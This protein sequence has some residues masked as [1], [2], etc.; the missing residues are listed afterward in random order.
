M[1]IGAADDDSQEEAMPQQETTILPGS[2]CLNDGPQISSPVIAAALR[3]L[4][5]FHYVL[6]TTSTT[7]QSPTSSTTST[8]TNASHTHVSTFSFDWFYAI[9]HCFLSCANQFSILSTF[10]ISNYIFCMY[11]CLCFKLKIS[12]LNYYLLLN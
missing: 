2:C 12:R 3:N 4:R 5:N 1:I 10:Y 8:I 7:T 6:T 9:L 11:F